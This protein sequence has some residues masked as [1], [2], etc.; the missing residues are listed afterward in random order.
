MLTKRPTRSTVA[1]GIAA[2][3]LVAATIT[4]GVVGTVVD[5]RTQAVD[6]AAAAIQTLRDA[7]TEERQA[8]GQL[9]GAVQRAVDHRAAV[10]DLAGDLAELADADEL[11]DLVE[12]TDELGAL[13]EQAEGVVDD[14][15]VRLVQVLDTDETPVLDPKASIDALQL[16]EQT[17]LEQT[18]PIQEH[19]VELR[20]RKEDL[21]SAEALV[22]EQ[23]GVVAGTTS[24]PSAAL[25]AGHEKAGEAATTAL[26]D[27][28]A[29]FESAGEDALDG[30]DVQLD[31]LVS[32][33]VAYVDAAAA[34][35]AAH[36]AAVAAEQQNAAEYTDPTTGQ[37]VKNPS[38]NPSVPTA[39]PA[40]SGGGGSAPEPV[41][42]RW[43]YCAS[44][45]FYGNGACLDA[46]PA[47]FTTNA[48]YIPFDSCDW[49]WYGAH[50]VGWGG[51]SLT[52]GNNYSFPWSA[53]VDGPTVT[54]YVCLVF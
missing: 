34:V 13:L 2:A 36:A 31:E 4:G 10:I 22:L 8:A 47:S 17:T 42:P 14:E 24:D 19:T 41:H 15:P 45:G 43:D 37:T 38:Y 7:R 11:A 35:S 32:A 18:E 40:G 51:T 1:A 9:T 54:Y 26:V 25:L 44:T 12:S 30:K 5:Q 39:P 46:I 23:L 16:L 52:G 6:A 20:D 3:A 27:A 33:G 28:Q 21:A 49:T 50:S 29:S 48:S 53:T